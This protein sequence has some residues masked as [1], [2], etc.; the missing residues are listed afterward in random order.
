MAF[1]FPFPLAVGVLIVDDVWVTEIGKAEAGLVGKKAGGKGKPDPIDRPFPSSSMM[2]FTIDPE[3]SVPS[4][5]G[6]VRGIEIP[7][8]TAVV[9]EE[10]IVAG[11]VIGVSVG[12]CETDGVGGGETDGTDG[13]GVYAAIIHL[14]IPFWT[15]KSPMNNKSQGF[16]IRVSFIQED[17]HETQ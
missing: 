5:G 16:R 9:L 10:V 1:A 3:N 6:G 17:N 7:F 12:R 15:P 11:G 13:I 14:S 2:D 8:I 4:V